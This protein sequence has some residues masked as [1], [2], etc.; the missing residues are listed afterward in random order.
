MYVVCSVSPHVWEC[1][2]SMCVV[3]VCAYMRGVYGAV[4]VC[5]HEYGVCVCMCAYVC[6]VWCVSV[7]ECEV[8]G[9]G[10]A[11]GVQCVCMGVSLCACRCV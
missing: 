8:C 6:V 4:R 3:C 5:V 11:C 7:C 10:S 9:C 2:V 1:L